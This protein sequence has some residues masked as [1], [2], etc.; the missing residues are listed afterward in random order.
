MSNTRK[1]RDRLREQ[2][3]FAVATSVGILALVVAILY[4][5]VKG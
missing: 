3:I 2:I 4:K 1:Q 5:A